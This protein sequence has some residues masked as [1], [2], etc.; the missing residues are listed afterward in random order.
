MAPRTPPL[1]TRRTRRQQALETSSDGSPTSSSHGMETP[2]PAGAHSSSPPSPTGLEPSAPLP[3]AS[4]N[5]QQLLLQELARLNNRLTSLEQANTPQPEPTTAPSAFT[6][7][8]FTA[9]PATPP[10]TYPGLDPS[11][12]LQKQLLDLANAEITSYLPTKCP[13]TLTLDNYPAWSSTI[14]GEVKLLN[15][16]TIL[17]QDDP[18]DDLPFNQ[19]IWRRKANIMKARMYTAMSSNAKDRLGDIT[20]LSASALWQHTAT[21]FGRSTGEERMLLYHELRNLYI[22][23]NDYLSYQNS[24]NRIANRLQTLGQL[25]TEGF[26]HDFFFIGLTNWN[27]AF[28]K[29]KLDE[30]YSTHRGP[31]HNLD[32][33][34]IQAQL[35]SRAGIQSR[36]SRD[37]RPRDP[38]TRTNNS[39]NRSHSKPVASSEH[40][41][42]PS[43]TLCNLCGLIHG[44]TC[45]RTYPEKAPAR[46]KDHYY[47][48]AYEFAQQKASGRST[49]S[50]SASAAHHP[51]V[52]SSSAAPSET[53]PAASKELIPFKASS[54]AKSAITM[55]AV[56]ST[57]TFT[58][59]VDSCASFHSTPHCQLFASYYPLHNVDLTPTDY[60]EGAQGYTS[61]PTGVGTVIL[62]IQEGTL[63]LKNVRHVPSFNSNLISVGALART[64]HKL[65]YSPDATSQYITTPSGAE[66]VAELGS[67]DVYHL[68]TCLNPGDESSYT[69][70][71]TRS[72]KQANRPDDSP[73]SPPSPPPAPTHKKALPIESWH[74]RLA[75]LNQPDILRLASD[76]H[77]PITIQGSKNLPFCDVCQQAKQTRQYSKFPRSRLTKPLARVHIDLTGGGRTLDINDDSPIP[78]RMGTNYVMIIT[79][80][81][82]RYRWLRYLDSKAASIDAFRVWL[83]HM[84]NFGYTAPACMVSDNEFQSQAWQDTYREEGIEWQPSA[85]YSPWQNAVSER[86]IRLLFERARSFMLDAPY[87]PQHFWA[88]ALHY[89][90]DLTNHLPTSTALY[91]TPTPGGVDRNPDIKPSPYKTPFST[92]TNSPEDELSSFHRWGCPVWVHRHGS[93]PPNN[94]LDS[95]SK[96]CFLLGHIAGNQ[97]RVWDPQTRDVFT[98]NDVLFNDEFKAPTSS[99]IPSEPLSEPIEPSPRDPSPDADEEIWLRPAKGFSVAHLAHSLTPSSTDDTPSTYKEAISHRD[100]PKWQEAMRKEVDQLKARNCWTLVRHQILDHGQKVIPGRWVYRK[101][102]LPGIPLSQDYKAKARWVIRGNLLDKDFM[103]S[104]A[105]VVNDTTTRLLTALTALLG[106]HTRQ[107]DATLAYLNGTLPEDKSVYMSQIQGFREGTQAEDLVCELRQSLYG[108]IPSARIWYDTLNQYLH[109]IGF[110]TS[111]YD[112]SL[113]IHSSRPHLYV[114][115][116]VDDFK[117]YAKQAVDADWFLNTLSTKFDINQVD[118]Q[119]KYLGTTLSRSSGS[120]DLTISQ[121]SY[122][123][124][125]VASFGLANSHPVGIPMDP[126]LQIDDDPDPSLNIKE[127]QRGTGALNWLAIKTRPDLSRAVGVLSQYNT[128]PTQQA[129]NALI[130]TLRYLKGSTDRHLTYHTTSGPPDLTP[131]CYT[132]SDWGGPLTGDRR[133]VSG[134]TFLLAGA[135]IAWRSRKQNSIALSSNEAEYMALSE[136]SRDTIWL[137]N[138]LLELKLPTPSSPNFAIPIFM[139]N[140]SAQAMAEADVTTKRSKH[141]DIRY[142]YSREKVRDGIIQIHGCPTAEQAADGLTKPLRTEQ[143]NRFLHLNGLT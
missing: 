114:T 87:I 107:A 140:L 30:V 134:Y 105:P 75:H 96:C 102:E 12:I 122:A 52:S 99:S 129:W 47:R 111:Q 115:T 118:D 28:V 85:P 84:K 50:S 39:S 61:K 23:D 20:G 90:K 38:P 106:W 35:A 17:T 110:H 126:G 10:A 37:S 127:Y 1:T 89:A 72:G 19:E 13:V 121:A 27:R 77:S 36:E 130:H 63:I 119:T 92:W 136:T 98:T 88:D 2:T 16:P 3:M 125:L 29:S 40:P 97:Y 128:K 5:T 133:S 8:A 112:S 31:V 49:P 93:D 113:W 56:A 82:T 9:P 139:D 71:T 43:H 21:L 86:G 64:D 66:F 117:I 46:F 143:F 48:K 109:E 69:L 81:A 45:F 51:S 142:H 7:P 58:W 6:A 41:S 83:R 14:E 73:S 70:V 116:H 104:Y 57:A 135:P 33:T 62:N 74:R 124:D 103:E 54:N 94:K 141:I 55:S 26:L 80:D 53:D 42:N 15:I 123:T 76:P 60:M 4:T 68:T 91:N 108:L 67:N 132:D 79:D 32:L 101:K 24:F 120:G 34:T 131:Q 137:R 44:P 59:F 78:S 100:A 138:I 11:T 22:K 65:Q 95:R 18:P 25:T